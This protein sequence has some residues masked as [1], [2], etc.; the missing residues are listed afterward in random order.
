MFKAVS[1]YSLQ[2]DIQYSI[3]FY[4][5]EN[6]ETE[7]HWC[8][9]GTH[10]KHVFALGHHIAVLYHSPHETDEHTLDSSIWNISNKNAWFLK[11]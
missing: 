2:K 6:R 1:S 5:I 9:K 3:L 4:S 8:K 7:K 11:V 10:S